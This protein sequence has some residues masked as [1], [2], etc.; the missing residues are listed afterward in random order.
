MM[1]PKRIVSGIICLL[2]LSSCATIKAPYNKTASGILD[3]YI[4]KKFPVAIRQLG[5]PAHIYTDGKDGRI[6]EWIYTDHHY[7]PGLSYTTGGFSWDD[8]NNTYSNHSIT[9]YRPPRHTSSSHYIQLYVH[10]NGT[11]YYYR[12]NVKSE[13]QLK[14]QRHNEKVKDRRLAGEILVGA[15]ILGVL[16]GLAYQ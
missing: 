15:A 9:L 14:A 5:P 8:F 11:I 10:K 4:G 13:A 7:M 3:T 6:L 12:H 1:K 2:L 16:F